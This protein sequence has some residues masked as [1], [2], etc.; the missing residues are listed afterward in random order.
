MRA[1][2]L[3]TTDIRRGG[4]SRQIGGSRAREIELMFAAMHLLV[5]QCLRGLWLSCRCSLSLVFCLFSSLAKDTRAGGRRGRW[6]VITAWHARECVA[7]LQVTDVRTGGKRESGRNPD[8]LPFS[9]LLSLFPCP[10]RHS[11]FK[12]K[13]PF[14][15]NDLACSPLAANRPRLF[16]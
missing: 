16:R 12:K 15:P 2:G 4:I 13:K 11:L 8:T 7:C 9:L 3:G 5:P 6:S 1:S 10:C 14:P